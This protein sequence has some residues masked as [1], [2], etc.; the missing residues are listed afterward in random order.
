MFRHVPPSTPLG[1]VGRYMTEPP[2]MYPQV[3]PPVKKKLI[4][5][6][7][8]KYWNNNKKLVQLDNTIIGYSYFLSNFNVFS[9]IDN[10]NNFNIVYLVLYFSNDSF[11]IMSNCSLMISSFLWFLSFEVW[12][13]MLIFDIQFVSKTTSL[14]LYSFLSRCFFLDF[15]VAIATFSIKLLSL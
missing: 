14:S 12:F 8:F 4:A 2:V 5:L 7:M 11:N 6:K 15:L 3:P 10:F 1:E 13:L 9:F